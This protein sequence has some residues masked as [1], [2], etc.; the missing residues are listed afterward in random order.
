MI[1]GGDYGQD[2]QY[3]IGG[4]GD[5]KIFSGSDNQGDYVTIYGDQNSSVIPND[6]PSDD[7][8]D[9][10]RGLEND[11]DD[12]I[13][14]GDNPDLSDG[15]YGYGMGGNDKIIGGIAPY[16]LLQGGDGDDK[17]WAIN[18]GQSYTGGADYLYGGDGKDIIYGGQSQAFIFG[19]FGEFDISAGLGNIYTPSV[20]GDDDILYAGAPLQVMF[21]GGGDDK[22]YGYGLDETSPFPNFGGPGGLALGEWGD[23]K[24]IG[25]NGI[26]ILIGDDFTPAIGTGL[27]L[28]EFDLDM[29]GSV[30]YGT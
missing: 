22:I 9:L 15:H 10:E 24:I 25:S 28:G 27:L 17:I 3:L 7:I 16:Q 14:F 4:Y 8:F 2:S 29:F 20:E 13:D 30:E 12:V 11:G 26:D 6:H 21:G 1:Y 23:D 18:P 19:D 5:D